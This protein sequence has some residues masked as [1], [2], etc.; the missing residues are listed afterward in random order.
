MV[1]QETI[2]NARRTCKP[3][4]TGRKDPVRYNDKGNAMRNA[5]I[6]KGIAIGI[7]V[8]VCVG[9]VARKAVTPETVST[10]ADVRK[11]LVEMDAR[12]KAL[13]ADRGAAPAADGAGT[14]A[15]PAAMRAARAQE[16]AN[17]ILI[18]RN[19]L[20]AQKQNRERSESLRRR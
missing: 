12:I 7:V 16:E 20:E 5:E 13:E 17:R 1:G 11:V 4:N 14:K 9:Q 3:Q 10:F 2:P 15:D 6:I 8:T 19:R 18:E